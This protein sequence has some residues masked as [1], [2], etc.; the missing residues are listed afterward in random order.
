MHIP[1]SS[2]VAPCCTLGISTLV[3]VSIVHG[4]TWPAGAA[5]HVESHP[6]HD[7][8]SPVSQEGIPVTTTAEPTPASLNGLELLLSE[9]AAQ[10]QPPLP[11]A[12]PASQPL[13]AAEVQPIWRI[14]CRRWKLRRP[15]SR[16]SSSRPG[17]RS[18]DRQR[19]RH[20]GPAAG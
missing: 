9:G 3:V 11:V 15:T 1:F 17:G 2:H 5:V 4:A 19:D 7:L 20:A 8:A 12:R 10:P 16:S 14:A 13:D 6:A 18:R